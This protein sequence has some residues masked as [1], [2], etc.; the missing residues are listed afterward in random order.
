MYV[1]KWGGEVSGGI[2]SLLRRE[3]NA[4]GNMVKASFGGNS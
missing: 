1:D 4:L 3:E 2:S